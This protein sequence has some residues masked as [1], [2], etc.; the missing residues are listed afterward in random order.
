MTK[1]IDYYMS[2][3]SPWA[4]L[5]SQ[6]FAEIA[7]RHGALVQVKPVTFGTVFAATG[8][9][10]LPQRAPQRQAYRMMELKRWKRRLGIPINLE[11][12]YFPVADPLAS[13]MILAAAQT[14]GDALAL[15]QAIGRACWEE[16][17]DIADEGT[18]REI[19]AATGHPPE[20]LVNAARDPATAS[21]IEA[22]SA[23]AIARGVFGAPSYVVDEEI[24][25]GQDRLEF[26]EEKLAG[27]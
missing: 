8:G 24:F 9:L 21:A 11:P 19:A 25:W 23:E 13:G 5:G 20:A 27:S 12:R 4:Y 14:D 17:R 6:R 1:Q 7:A 10:P 2:P 26:L 3:A 16:E 18:L 15:A 22:L